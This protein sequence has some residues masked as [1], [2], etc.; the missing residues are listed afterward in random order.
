[1]IKCKN[2][3]VMNIE[4]A[5]NGM[6]NPMKSW[7]KSDSEW[8][9][10]TKAAYDCK[11]CPLIE[12]CVNG[13]MKEDGGYILGENDLKLAKSLIKAGTDERK[14]LRQIFISIDITAPLFWWKEMDT[15]K[16][17]TVSNSTSTMHKLTDERLTFTDFSMENCLDTC[18]A[19]LDI[20][21]PQCE[22]LRQQYIETGDKRYWRALIE[23]LPESFN[24]TR[25]WTANYE[26][27][28]NI[29]HA[30]KN[31]KLD[32]WKEFCKIIETLPYAKELICE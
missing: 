19:F 1:M 11:H 3:T 31:H 12:S 9:Y 6:R 4:N 28:R 20:L 16:V 18:G 5:I 15:Y 8:C 7:I 26:T 22:Y 17:A 25:T 10:H 2:I 23:I 21:I 14:F 13:Y 32:E 24:Q 27:L 29:Y 30:R